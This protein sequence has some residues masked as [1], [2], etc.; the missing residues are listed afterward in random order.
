MR[1]LI[2]LIISIL[3]ASQ[4]FGA[5]LVDC[6]PNSQSRLFDYFEA[7]NTHGYRL[8][9]PSRG[10][11]Q[12]ITAVLL[13]RLKH[14]DQYPSEELSR[15]IEKL[16]S[17]LKLVKV[18][19]PRNPEP[20]AVVLP[21]S[22][23]LKTISTVE[24]DPVTG[25]LKYLV[26][27]DRW[28]KIP[29][30]IRAG[31]LLHDALVSHARP[32]LQ[33]SARMH[34]LKYDENKLQSDAR[35][36][37]G[38]LAVNILPQYSYENYHTF[39]R[40]SF[41]FDATNINGYL[42]VD[43]KFNTD[44]NIHSYYI[45]FPEGGVY[46]LPN[47]QQLEMSNRSRVRIENHRTG[48]LKNLQVVGAHEAAAF[49]YNGRAFNAKYLELDFDINGKLELIKN[50]KPIPVYMARLGQFIDLKCSSYS[51]AHDGTQNIWCNQ[52]SI[53]LISERSSYKDGYTYYLKID[54][55]GKI[56]YAEA[57]KALFSKENGASRFIEADF[58]SNGSVKSI[59]C[60]DGRTAGYVKASS[61]LEC[62]AGNSIHYYENGQIK[63]S[64]ARIGHIPFKINNSD[65]H[66]GNS[67]F[68]CKSVAGY[69]GYPN[70]ATKTVI[71]FDTVTGIELPD[72]RLTYAT[73]GKDLILLDDTGRVKEVLHNDCSPSF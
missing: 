7:E 69:E 51:P 36:L 8:D 12:E 5:Q 67:P 68:R 49:V 61:S 44:G 34:N 59:R 31:A 64:D 1:L 28:Q 18:T 47:G 15:Q 62:K 53:D 58:F 29:E 32:L 71:A 37:V 56:Q 19:E 73:K 27:A 25:D 13:K 14:H 54:L 2:S 6:G 46:A 55:N 23:K 66:F 21:D 17:A 40:N 50:N 45:V 16:K 24:I 52:T 35:F 41:E 72:G 70:G 10:N 26:D 60:L 20:K 57:Y 3:A 30:Q 42:V 33:K 11:A 38:V 63:T 4:S 48:A 22:C 9:L 65:W 39:M 43:L